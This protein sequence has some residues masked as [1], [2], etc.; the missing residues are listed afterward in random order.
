MANLRQFK[1]R[2]SAT[3]FMRKHGVTKEYYNN[4]LTTDTV[5]G[6]PVFV[7]DVEDMETF[8]DLKKLDEQSGGNAAAGN[9]SKEDGDGNITQGEYYN[10]DGTLKQ[11]EKPTQKT[12]QI[13]EQ[14]TAPS[15]LGKTKLGKRLRERE[16]LNKKPKIEKKARKQIKV[17]PDE[18]TGKTHGYAKLNAERQTKGMGN[19]PATKN[20]LEQ[21]PDLPV[22]SIRATCLYLILEGLNN[23]TVF[24][25]M[26]EVF[27]EERCKGKAHYPQ[28]YRNELIKTNQLDEKGKPRK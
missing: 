15:D 17:K 13:K 23:E 18:Q 8:I 26:K 9:Y 6:K 20:I 7:V 27:G 16:E 4:F 28:A 14:Q 25:A 19:A 22:K 11:D 5:G 21:F 2:D 3:A 12:E 24:G 1:T 10:E